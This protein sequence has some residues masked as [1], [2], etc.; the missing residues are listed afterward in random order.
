MRPGDPHIGGQGQVQ[1]RTHGGAVD[2]GDRRQRAATH[3]HE[4]GVD[5]LQP[6]R[7]GAQRQVRTRAE[8]L[9]RPADDD[10]VDVGIDSARLTASRSRSDISAV[11]AFAPVRVVDGDE[12]DSVADVVEKPKL[13]WGIRP[14]GGPRHELLAARTP[15]GLPGG[16]NFFA[17]PPEIDDDEYSMCEGLTTRPRFGPVPKGYPM[18]TIDAEPFPLDF[19]VDSTA[20]RHHRHAARLRATRWFRRGARQRHLTRCWRRSSRSSGCSSG[21]V[22]SGCS[23]C[24]PG[25]PPSGS[26]RTVRRRS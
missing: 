9:A 26:D 3:G 12:R 20:P 16:K 14:A 10:G 1:A 15:K 23:S 17:N 21:P 2:R 4:S 18:A 7:G 6:S 8:R 19:E 11:T 13:P 24:T 5:P 22:R 25:R